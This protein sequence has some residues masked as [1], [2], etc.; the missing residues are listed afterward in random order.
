MIQ[1][2]DQ[3][4]WRGKHNEY[5]DDGPVVAGAKTRRFSIFSR[6]DRS[7]LGYVKW[8]N[9][10]RCYSLFP[11]NSVFHPD[12]LIEIVT[13]CQEATQ[14]HKDRI[15]P[16]KPKKLVHRPSAFVRTISRRPRP[17]LAV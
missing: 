3:D 8:F 12:I 9:I 2:I 16:P 5:R 7:L 13:F 14:A 11:L 4:W 15:P 10:S 17:E 1:R 6:R